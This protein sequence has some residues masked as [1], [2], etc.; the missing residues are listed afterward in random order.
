[1]LTRLVNAKMGIS[2]SLSFDRFTTFITQASLNCFPDVNTFI[3]FFTQPAIKV[4]RNYDIVLPCFEPHTIAV[5]IIDSLVS[6][7]F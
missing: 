3:T 7:L 5:T 1:M 4:T 6:Q 2:N